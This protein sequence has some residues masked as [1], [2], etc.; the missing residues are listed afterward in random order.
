[1]DNLE[2][3]MIEVATIA[4]E[5]WCEALRRSRIIRNV[6][7]V[8]ATLTLIMRLTCRLV[9]LALLEKR[10]SMGVRFVARLD[11]LMNMERIHA[12]HV[13]SA[14]LALLAH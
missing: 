2:F 5:G 11:H 3:L 10:Q 4:L 6:R 9:F 12:L 1:M 8:E 13:Q 14:L 7:F